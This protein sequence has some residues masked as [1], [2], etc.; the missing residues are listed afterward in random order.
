MRKFLEDCQKDSSGYKIQDKLINSDPRIKKLDEAI[1][2]YEYVSLG[3][4]KQES[5][6]QLNELLD[7]YHV[8]AKY[9]PAKDYRYHQG[10]RFSPLESSLKIIIPILII[11][12]FIFLS[13]NKITGNA[14]AELSTNTSSWVGGVLLIV[15]LVVSFF[16]L[17]SKTK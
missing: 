4:E 11:G 12:V 10:F 5:Q 7:E 15:G 14:I 2:K 13:Y 6:K 1:A 17:K 3:S 8:Q 9:I 16:W